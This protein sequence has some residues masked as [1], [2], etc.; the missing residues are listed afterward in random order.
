MRL[1]LLMPKR[2]DPE[3]ILVL[4]GNIQSSSMAVTTVYD[5]R[6]TVTE[7]SLGYRHVKPM[8]IK[9]VLR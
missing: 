3:L 6:S 8:C 5:A 1:Q 7:E 2:R 9:Q 4:H